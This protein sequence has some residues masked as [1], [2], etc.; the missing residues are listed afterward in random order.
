MA[1]PPFCFFASYYGAISYFPHP[2]VGRILLRDAV[3]AV[4]AA[5]EGN[6]GEVTR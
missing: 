2:A 4:V 1:R 6:G 3:R 5:S